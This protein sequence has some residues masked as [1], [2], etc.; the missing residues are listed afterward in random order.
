MFLSIIIPIYNVEKYIERCARSLMEQTMKDGIEFLFINDCTPD[1]SMT[2]LRRVIANYPER[3][4][5]IRII[6]NN[7]NLGVSATRRLGVNEANGDYIGWCDSDDWVESEAF[8]RMY[9]ATRQGMIDIVVAPFIKEKSNGGVEIV[10]FNQC[11]TPQEC[12]QK[13]WKGFF[14]PGALWQQICR[15]K[16]LQRAF[17][18]IIDTNYSEDIFTLWLTYHFSQSINYILTPY[19]HYNSINSLSLVHN[20]S[21][22]WD[23]WVRQKRNIDIIQKELYRGCKDKQYRVACNAL[24]YGMKVQYRFAFPNIFKYYYTYRECYFD[25]NSFFFTPPKTRLKTF[26]VY[27][28]FILFWFY[29][30]KTWR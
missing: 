11:H 24:K 4:H 23:S 13:S 29:N 25:V 19:Y 14:F 6:E 17:N 26:L 8:E 9:D 5:Q 10:R 1:N 7:K 21:Y 12:I 22:S 16:F 30:R 28:F 3:G 15:K 18:L 2:I 27:N 20:I